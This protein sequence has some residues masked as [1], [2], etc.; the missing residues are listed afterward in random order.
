MTRITWQVVAVTAVAYAVLLGACETGR[1]EELKWD[2]VATGG[3]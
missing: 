2:S 3:P 1:A